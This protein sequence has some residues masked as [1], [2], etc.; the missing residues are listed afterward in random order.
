[1]KRLTLTAPKS[2]FRRTK[3]LIKS[4]FVITGQES[5]S[6][7]SA[8]LA[9]KEYPVFVAPVVSRLGRRFKDGIKQGLMPKSKIDGVNEV[10]NLQMQAAR[11][12]LRDRENPAESRLVEE[13]F[14]RPAW[15]AGE[16]NRDNQ[17]E[18]AKSLQASEPDIVLEP[19]LIGPRVDGPWNT[20]P[21]P[22]VP[23]ETTQAR[24][25]NAPLVHTMVEA[26]PDSPA[27]E[28]GLS[29]FLSEDLQ[30]IFK[31][32]DYTNPRT[33]ALLESREHVDVHALAK[34]LDEYARSIGAVPRPP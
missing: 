11:D 8:G 15:A 21:E 1:M 7:L 6:R 26:I 27:S 28:G 13:I 9:K 4:R 17:P 16:P 30:D 33:K 34:E 2:M 5:L 24:P 23:E 22:A 12:F 14:V 20:D 25:I 31:T 10:G 32:V 18:P 19:D 3:E 29:D